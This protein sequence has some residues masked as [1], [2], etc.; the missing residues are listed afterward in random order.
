MTR[1]SELLRPR[2]TAV[3]EYLIEAMH[4]PVGEALRHS[5]ALER[6]VE[7]PEDR[8]GSG[9][10]PSVPFTAVRS[11]HLDPRRT[12]VGSDEHLFP[13]LF[14][15]GGDQAPVGG[16]SS[17]ERS[18]GSRTEAVRGQDG[19]EGAS[20][21][22]AGVS[23]TPG[24][25]TSPEGSEGPQ[26][27]PA[28]QYGRFP[29]VSKSLCAR[30]GQTVDVHYLAHLAARNGLQLPSV[31]QQLERWRRIRP[32]DTRRFEFKVVPVGEVLEPYAR[33]NGAVSAAVIAKRTWYSD[34][35]VLT[36]LRARVQAHAE[37]GAS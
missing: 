30:E 22:S 17:P 25:G 2:T 18:N 10:L 14:P 16:T 33:A 37:A 35:H 8:Q 31:I 7:G 34:N 3:V 1:Q 13:P 21:G 24:N 32:V 15:D 26:R 28:F 9:A 20:E 12:G 4:V 5:K 29:L 27:K 23:G 19:A 6:L 36:W 11:P